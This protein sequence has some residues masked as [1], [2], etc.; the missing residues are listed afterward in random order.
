MIAKMRIAK[1]RRRPICSSGI[2]AFMMDF[3]TTCKPAPDGA[4]RPRPPPALPSPP[5]PPRHSLGIPE[6]SLRGRSTRTARSVRRSNWEPTVARM[7]RARGG[8][9]A[10]RVPPQQLAPQRGRGPPPAMPPWPPRA[11]MSQHSHVPP[12]AVPP[13][14]PRVP[15]SPTEPPNLRGPPL[16]PRLHR[17][18]TH[19]PHVPAA[20]PP[21]HGRAVTTT[22]SPHVPVTQP[23]A[24][25]H[26]IMATVSPHVP[27]AWPRAHSHAIT[28]TRSPHV[29]AA[30]PRAHGHAVRAGSRCRQRGRQCWAI[31][32]FSGLS[33]AALPVLMLEPGLAWGVQP[34]AGT[35]LWGPQGPR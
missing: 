15:T 3:R 23:H 21:D 20:C 1:N 2:I 31:F 30:W 9:S 4:E 28:A 7:L 17:H 26:A 14:P 33:A 10:S 35:S 29:P 25:G 5:A 8:V 34:L 27:A 13:R 24:H 18:S 16:V 19:K 6:T 32:S 11:T 22:V 12:W